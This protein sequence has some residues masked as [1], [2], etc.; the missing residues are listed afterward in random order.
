MDLT[1]RDKFS[2]YSQQWRSKLPYAQNPRKQNVLLIFCGLCLIFLVTAGFTLIAGSHGNKNGFNGGDLN[3]VPNQINN[4]QKS[5]SNGSSASSANST[6]GIQGKSLVGSE[7]VV[8]GT[9][10]D[11]YSKIF[12]GTPPPP[13]VLF[14]AS[15]NSSAGSNN[16]KYN[17]AGSF[18]SSNIQHSFASGLNTS[19]SN[20]TNLSSVQLYFPNPT[21]ILQ[22]YVTPSSPPINVNWQTYVNFN[23]HYTI[24]I[25]MG[26]QVVRTFYDG[27]EGVSLYP[28]GIATT[29]SVQNGLKAVGFGV[30]QYNYQVPY[31]S[32][33]QST[34][35]TP[36]TINGYSGTLYTQ[37][38]FGINTVAAIISYDND[39]FGIG[40]TA[41]TSDMIYVFQ[42]MLDSLHLYG[43]T[44]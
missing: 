36:I 33:S 13:Q 9:G 24:S 6:S 25:P 21:G 18:S 23:D 39:Y 38:S 14:S 30:S 44:F 43:Q 8:R 20:N 22:A 3:R 29:L 41:N 11:K 10:T 40:A 7:S 4:A 42:Y 37:G 1:W 17:S 27:H 31:I 5:R 19:K 34:Y 32:Q 28:P 16:I 26:W 35:S 15:S 2:Y 12:T